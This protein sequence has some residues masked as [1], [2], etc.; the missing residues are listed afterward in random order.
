MQRISGTWQKRFTPENI[1]QKKSLHCRYFTKRNEA[2]FLGTRKNNVL[3]RARIEPIR[4]DFILKNMVQV[5]LYFEEHG[6][7]RLYFEKY[8]SSSTL[9][10]RTRFSST[11]F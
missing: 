5:R 8:G 7:V 3:T 10:R 11:L 1:N 2:K 6:S 4:F 9:F